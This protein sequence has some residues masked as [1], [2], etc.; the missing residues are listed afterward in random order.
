MVHVL[1]HVI[2]EIL[3]TDSSYWVILKNGG[4]E[5]GRLYFHK[6]HK[7]FYYPIQ[8][9]ECDVYVIKIMIWL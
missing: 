2:D 5:N 4:S 6:I 8:S 9:M 3:N 1:L 7:V